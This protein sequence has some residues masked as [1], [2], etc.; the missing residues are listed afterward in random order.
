ME[1]ASER[2]AT[3]EKKKENRKGRRWAAMLAKMPGVQHPCSS[4]QYDLFGIP[5]VALQ[6]TIGAL[7][8]L[9][10]SSYVLQRF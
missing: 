10:L 1:K 5:R 7:E 8:P 4:S 3:R 9:G 6:R 2:K